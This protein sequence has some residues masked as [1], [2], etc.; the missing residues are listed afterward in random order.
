MR[1]R[2]GRKKPASRIRYEQNHPVVS[3]RVSKEL[4]NSLQV[5]KKM[6]GKSFTDI[7]KVGLGLLEVKMHKEEEIRKEGY[8][9]GY[10]DG[11]RQAE[12]LY[13][14]ACPCSKCG[15]MMAVTSDNAKKAIR[16]FMIEHRWGHAEC[17]DR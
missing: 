16:K 17:P 13:K 1:K 4:Y 7:L 10:N 6:E 12:H 9:A 8:D 11:F 2:K 15:K 3:S 14:I 5:V